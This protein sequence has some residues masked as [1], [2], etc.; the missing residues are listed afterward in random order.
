MNSATLRLNGCSRTSEYPT[1]LLHMGGALRLIFSL[2][3]SQPLNLDQVA[4]SAP[5]LKRPSSMTFAA[6]P[7]PKRHQGGAGA[8]NVGIVR[9]V[10]S[11]VTNEK[12]NGASN[13]PTTAPA[14]QPRSATPR[15]ALWCM[16]RPIVLT[17]W[18]PR[19]ISPSWDSE[20]SPSRR[21][22]HPAHGRPS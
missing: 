19:Y 10:L 6:A 3:R 18:C 2:I 15:K 4:P 8:S 12:A 17:K 22:G 5:P 13:M 11:D 20:A 1:C 16:P 9:S 7:E 21:R 14:V